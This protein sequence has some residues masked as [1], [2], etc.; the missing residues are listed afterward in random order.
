MNAAYNGDVM[1]ENSVRLPTDDRAFR[2]GD[3]L[4]E[5]IRYENGIVWFWPDHFDR[6]NRGM[7]AMRLIPPPRFSEES[8]LETIIQLLESNHLRQQPARLKLQ[9]WRRP[10]G[11]Y[12]PATQEADWLLTVRPG[13]P[14]SITPK[15]NLG[16][17]EDFRL[18]PSPVSAFKTLNS[19]PYVLA[20]LYRQ[21]H[22]YDDVLLLDIHGYLAE[23]G[24]SNLFWFVGETLFTPSLETGCIDGVLRRQLLR[25][26]DVR[27]GLFPPE[28]LD[29]ADCI[30]CA[31]VA[32]IQV[33]RG[34]DGTRMT[35]IERIF[36]NFQP[37]N[38]LKGT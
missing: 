19:L 20:A 30:F 26:F 4:F 12:T 13:P 22:G 3:G 9:V 10:G 33:F 38:P 23:C 14:F 29:T 35:R 37:L 5:T 1:S 16:V 25:H 6:L 36:A 28:A 32:G 17:Y 24:A 31:N 15:S 11:L 34:W 21:E 18:S 27:E 7:E 2:Y 8:L